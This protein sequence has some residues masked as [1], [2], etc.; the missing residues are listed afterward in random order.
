MSACL[1]VSGPLRSAQL[2][3]CI[4]VLPNSL[5]TRMP[6]SMVIPLTMTLLTVWSEAA[7]MCRKSSQEPL[8]DLWGSGPCRSRLALLPLWRCLELEPAWPERPMDRCCRASPAA[9]APAASLSPFLC[10]LWPCAGLSPPDIE[11][12]PFFPLSAGC[13]RGPCRS[14]EPPCSL[15]KETHLCLVCFPLAK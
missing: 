6:A 2:Y 10:Q 5:F 4:V 13:P 8:T 14:A 7:A 3:L 12:T 1:G 11:T 9:C 15:S